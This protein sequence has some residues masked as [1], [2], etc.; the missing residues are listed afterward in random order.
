MQLIEMLLYKIKQCST[1]DVEGFGV[2]ILN[3]RCKHDVT[4]MIVNSE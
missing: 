1:Y 4:L 2:C 3:L